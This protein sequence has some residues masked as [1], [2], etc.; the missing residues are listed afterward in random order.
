MTSGKQPAVCRGI[1][2]GSSEAD[3]D[4]GSGSSLASLSFLSY[5][6]KELVGQCKAPPFEL[7]HY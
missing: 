4:R 6:V 5:K 1:A 3:G 7:C 2:L